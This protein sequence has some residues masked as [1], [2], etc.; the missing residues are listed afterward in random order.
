MDMGRYRGFHLLTLATTFLE[1]LLIASLW[2]RDLT[3][4][5]RWICEYSK[6]HKDCYPTSGTY[7]VKDKEFG[8]GLSS[9]RSYS[10]VSDCVRA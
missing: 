9:L 10:V 8:G 6:Q 3:R 7:F 4:R 5:G 2:L 1:P